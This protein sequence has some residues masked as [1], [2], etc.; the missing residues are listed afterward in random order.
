MDAIFKA[1]ND[2]ARRRLLD[3]LREKD[4]Q[5]L[6]E[7]E[8][9]MDM[10]RFGVMKH[11]AVLEAAGLVVPRRAGR[12][13]HHYLNTVPLQEV[14]DR[15]IAPLARPAARAVI[16]LKTRLEGGPAMPA[17]KPDF[18]HQTII[19]TTPARLWEALLS[20]DLTRQYYFDT[21]VEGRAEPGET[22]V[23][24]G[25]D[26]AAMLEGRVLAVEPLRR[27]DLTFEPHF[28]PGKPVSRH[29]FLI[30]D[31]GPACRLTIEHYDLPEAMK[32]IR[33]GWVLIASRLKTLLET[34]ESLPV[35]MAMLK[36]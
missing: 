3:S 19:R 15:W 2:P 27:L 14:I 29:V 8:A 4:G 9:Q 23:W 13:K 5:T 1:L 11:L 18:I 26:G 34:G 17:E 22:L 16:D 32:G 21:R 33:D 28:I 36:G 24:R 25:E 10:T 6:T 30:E 12:F 7:L 20:G 35:D 31:L